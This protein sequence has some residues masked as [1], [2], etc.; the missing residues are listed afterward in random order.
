M[1]ENGQ[2]IGGSGA[3]AA[4]GAWARAYTGAAAGMRWALPAGERPASVVELFVD[5]RSWCYRLVRRSDG[6]PARDSR[7]GYLYV[8]VLDPVV[9]P[10]VAG[11]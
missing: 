2:F 5:R 10:R 6:T 9:L 4:G 8:P 11:R 7:G 1:A 3:P